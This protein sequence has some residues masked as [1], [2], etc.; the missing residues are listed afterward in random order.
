VLQRDKPVPVWGT[1]D[2]G[3]KIT[4]SFA[5]QSVSTH[6]DNSGKWRVVLAPQ[7]ANVTPA[8]L[9]IA[10]NNTI[11]FTNILVGEVWLASG[12]SN[13]EQIL[14]NTFDASIDIPA[15][16]NFP[17]IRHIKIGR[18]ISDAPQATA[19]GR[20]QIPGPATTG[21]FSAVAYYFALDVHQV[22]KVPVGIIH[23]SL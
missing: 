22:V 20:W 7:P 21:G 17:L 19:T 18:Q 16:A 10:G 15:S 12:Q 8:P 4:V 9:V 5:G 3:E 23:S 11:T 6:A 13:M 14:K 2:V 1:A